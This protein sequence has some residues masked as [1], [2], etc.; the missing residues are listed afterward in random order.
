LTNDDASVLTPFAAQEAQGPVLAA[1]IVPH[2]EDRATDRIWEID[3]ALAGKARPSAIRPAK[4]KRQKI[5][6]FEGRE[7]TV[8]RFSFRQRFPHPQHEAFSPPS[9]A[10]YGAVCDFFADVCETRSQA[11]TLLS[12]RD[13]AEI[14]SKSFPFTAPRRRLIWIC[15]TAFILSDKELRSRVRAWDIRCWREG[16]SDIAC[17]IAFHKPFKQVAKFAQRLI[18][19]MR[20]QG[21]EIFG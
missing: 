9:Q 19:D 15:A 18:D 8:E 5:A 14:V 16:S 20:S 1:E 13:Y 10:Q 4:R 6:R 3:L 12:A 11:A 17:G 7:G 21:A 2:V